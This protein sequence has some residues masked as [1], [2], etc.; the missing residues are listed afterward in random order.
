VLPFLGA[1]L[2]DRS[3]APIVEIAFG[4]LCA[5]GAGW[6]GGFDADV[7]EVVGVIVM[8]IVLTVASGRGDNWAEIKD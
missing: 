6:R 8:L 4:R 7:F 5:L 1:V 3:G 2:P